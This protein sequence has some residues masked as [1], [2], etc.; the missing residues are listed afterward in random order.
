MKIRYDEYV[1][2][3]G[4]QCE[5]VKS[6][7]DEALIKLKE[8]MDSL[9]IAHRDIRNGLNDDN[10]LKY[11]DIKDIIDEYI[12]N[13]HSVTYDMVTDTILSF[14]S[15]IEE[16]ALIKY[17]Y[18]VIPNSFLLEVDDIYL[19]RVNHIRKNLARMKD[20]TTELIKLKVK[21]N[22]GENNE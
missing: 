2:L 12:I 15:Y 20:K 8:D 5:V 17:T 10:A 9:I 19:D 14:L 7:L 6:N 11:F 13:G 1:S 16:G 22:D 18:D 3:C 21:M 4:M